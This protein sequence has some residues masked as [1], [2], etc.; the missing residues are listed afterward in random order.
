MNPIV[1]QQ[2]ALDN[3]LVVPEERLKIK[4]CNMRIEFTKRR[5]EPTY[6]VTLDVLKLSP[7]YLAF[8]ITVEKL[9]L[10]KERKFKKIA[11]P[12][13]K[14]TL[15]LKEESAK[16]P[17]DTPGLSVSKK[18]ALLTTKRSNDIDLLS[19][20]TLLEDSHMKKV[21]KQSK[22]ET[23]SHQASGS[24]TG[25]IPRVPDVPKDQS[26]SENE[27]WRG[28]GDDDINDD[29]SD[30][31]DNDD[32][33]DN[34][35]GSDDERIESDKD[36]NPNLN[37]NDDGIEEEYEDEYVHTPSSYESTNDEN[38][39]VDE[40][41]YDHIDEELYIDVNVKLNDVEHGEE[42]KGDAEKTDAADNEIISMMNVDVR[43]EEPS[44]QTPSL[45]TILI[46][47]I[48]G[49]SIAAATTIPPPI[50]PF[51]PPLHQ[52]TPTPTLTPIPTTT[53]IPVLLG[54]SSL[55]EFNQRV[56]NLEKGL[57]ELKQADQSAQLLAT[58]KLQLPVMVG[59]DLVWT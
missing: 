58:I 25:T 13:K 56:S 43:H 11:S 44:N 52:S 31:D 26:E 30:D 37:Q 4:K 14:Q 48:P 3:A 6:Q 21:L 27:S 22:R 50:P 33:C 23:H 40:E 1:A 39:H 55:F 20:A 32:D 2:V 42:G 47:I 46:T 45:I 18:K 53:I 8:L 5:R 19:E 49:T 51:I 28:S 7:C 10:K 12:L 57:S 41:E 16:K 54:F 24:G 59:F 17:K 36:E 9:L 34:N 29:N 38:E 35:D 15:V